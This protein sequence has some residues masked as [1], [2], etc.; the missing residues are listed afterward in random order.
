MIARARDRVGVVAAL[1]VVR[2]LLAAGFAVPVVSLVEGAGVSQFVE[3]DALLFEPSGLYLTELLRLLRPELRALGRNYLY[4]ALPVLAVLIFSR[5]ALVTALAERGRLSFG[6]WLERAFRAFPS[7]LL[8]S[9]LATLLRVLVLLVAL[10]IGGSTLSVTEHYWDERSADLI[11]LSALLV[12]LLP[13]L[14]LPSLADLTRA[15]VV[16]QRSS[17]SAALFES[18]KLFRRRWA[19]VL[20]AWLVP[21]LAALTLSLAVAYL[22]SI[23]DVGQPGGWRVLSVFGLHQFVAFALVWFDAVW[24]ARALAFSQTAPDD[25]SARSDEPVDPSSSPAASPGA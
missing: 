9:G 14:A 10:Q 25:R 22:V 3:G 6:A 16:L 4:L 11:A 17:V 20:L 18:A 13:L 8:I 12:G 1:Y 5:A 24:L 19:S 15:R 7:F 21:H 2:S 23:I